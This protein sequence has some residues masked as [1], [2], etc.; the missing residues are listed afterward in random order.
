MA[1]TI[2]TC[3]K[4]ALSGTT[5]AD[6]IDDFHTWIAAN[7]GNFTVSNAVGSPVTSFT[8]THTNGWQINYRLSGGVILSLIAPSGG[9]SDSAAP[10]TP[11]N[12]SP[13]DTL[14]P[15]F[16]GTSATALIA[17]YDD[18]IFCGI[19][20]SAATALSY[21]FMQGVVVQIT[22]KTNN[23]PSGLGVFAYLIDGSPSATAFKWFSVT[24]T[25]GNRK[26]YIQINDTDWASLTVTRN[27]E[28]VN[29]AGAGTRFSQEGLAAGS[30]GDTPSST[31]D[32]CRGVLKYLYADTV[33]T[34]AAFSVDPS[35]GFDQGQLAVRDI[36]TATR[37]RVLWDKTV[38]P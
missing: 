23:S 14:L 35:S 3:V 9:I 17:R 10:G 36:T 2:P 37:M 38:T 34:A 30:S 21:A 18:A 32:P 33:T 16:S 13:E 25:A 22:S 7:P 31:S 8:L 1:P 5:A 12:A 6:W 20:N 15:A 28:N 27:L 26:S 24:G 19:K 29:S 11:T 4:L